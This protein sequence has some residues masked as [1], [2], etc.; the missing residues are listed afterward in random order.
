MKYLLDTHIWIW[1]LQN[2]GKL[3]T[4]VK[5][6]LAKDS[7]ELYLSPVSIWEARLLEKGKRIRIRG[8][9]FEWLEKAL[10]SAPL[11]EAPFNFAVASAAAGIELPQADPGDIFLAA[12]ALTMD[13]TLITSDTQLIDVSWLKIL[14]NR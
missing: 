9:F 12:T 1:A 8:E 13:L 2:P 4:Q 11:R 3:S 14:S 6:Q 10:V 7:N 5:R